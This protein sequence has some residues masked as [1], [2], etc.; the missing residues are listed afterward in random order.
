MS[1]KWLENVKILKSNVTIKLYHINFYIQDFPKF[2][3]QQTRIS[4]A[5]LTDFTLKNCLP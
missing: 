5:G 1:K 4:T 3:Q 2:M